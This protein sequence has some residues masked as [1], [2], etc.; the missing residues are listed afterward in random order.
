MT[1]REAFESRMM[2]LDGGMGSVIQTYGIKGANNDMLSIERPDVILD[3]QR[4]YVDAG[5]D[6][7]TTNTFSSQRVSQH[8]YHQEHRIAEMNR[9]SV[10]IARQAA[11]EAMAKY[12]RQV[13]IAGDVGPTS[14]MLS[15][16]DDVNDPASRS[17]TF[18][19]LEDAY[20]EQIQVLLEEGV[21]A[22]LIE[23]IFDTLNAKAALSAYSKAK[24]AMEAAAIA[25][26][27]TPRPVEV[28]LSMTVS[29]ASGRTL[30]GQT[31]EAFAISVMH[32]KPLSIGL[33]CGLGADGMIPYLRRMGK[34]A[35]CYLSCHPNAGLPNQFGGYDDTPEDMVRLMTPYMD[36]HLVNMIGGCCGTTPEHIAAM[37]K[38]LD[39]LP[40]DYERRKPAPKFATSPLLRLAGLEPLLVNQVRPSNGADNCNS[41][42]FVPVGERCNV[43]GS[44]KFLR[45]INEKNYEEALDIARK[46]V[47][48]GAQVVDVNMD[49]GLLDAKQEMRTFLNL[50]ASDPA[51][52]RVPIMVD[53]SR[54][55][56]IEEGLKCAQGKCIVNSISLKM[57]EEAFIEHAMT[58][59][60]LGAAVIVML[61]DEEGQATNY[62]RRVAI[63]SRAYK[64]ITEKCGFDPSDIIFDPNVLTVATGMAEH[65]AYAHDFIR[66]C[67][68]IIDNLPGVRISGGL[69]NL[70]FAF[71][72]N[73][74]LREAMHSTFLHLATPNGMG[75]AIMNPAAAVDYKTI[76]LELRMAITEVLLNTYPESS[77]ELIEIASRMTAAQ[78]AAKES[79]AK[80]DPKAIFAVSAGAANAASSES[81]GA[82]VA[83]VQTTPEQRLQEALLKGTSTTLQPD[84]ME[85]INRG[86]SPVNIISGPLMDGM[87]EVGRLFGEGKMF[88]PQVVKTARTMKKAV[89]ILQPYIEAGKEEG[90]ASR[91]KIVIATVKGDVHD[92]G[93]NIVSVIMA[94]NG[95][96]MVDLGVMVPEDVIVNA[97]IEHKADIVS[98]SGLITPSLEEMCTVATK[99]QEAGLRIPIIVG[100]ATTSPTHTAVKIAPCYDGPVFHVRDAASNPGLA[101][102][103]LDPSTSAETIEENRKEQQ[104][105]RDKQAGIISAAEEAMAAA[106]STPVERRYKCDWEKYQPV[107]PPFMGESKLPPI[108]LE[109]VIP[110]ISWEYFF[111]TWKVKPDC[112]EAIKLK[113]DAEKLLAEI[114]KPEYALRAVQAFYPAAGTDSTVQFNTGRTGT[115]ADLVEVTT[116]RQQ[117]PEGTCLALCDYVAP[118]DAKTASV[119]S[120]VLGDK[121]FRD[122][123]G[124]FAVTVSDT[125]VKRLEKLKAEQG[126]SD[127]DVLL[128]QTVAD[129]LAEAGA[130]YLSN[131]LDANNN[132]KG[133]RPAVGYPVLPNI[134]EIFN[135]AKLIDFDSVGISLTEN[136]AMYPQASVSGLYISHP[137]IEYF[138]VK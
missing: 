63:A 57:G 74:Y 41:E 129:R 101:Q 113:A 32:A 118:A 61:F 68:W 125:F 135:V 4:R 108:A 126:G 47:E 109:K 137:E 8:E 62:D 34:V 89:E 26:G 76:P 37:R 1:L 33:N 25:K 132:W 30:S 87:N 97:A 102:K 16:S 48:D 5:V 39:A 64:L 69:S 23:T 114:S 130:Q 80:Y 22:I 17:I 40:A 29:D 117:N 43:A 51:I 88:L 45:L 120:S 83:A 128:M 85:L 71:R 84:L 18:D 100:G 103:L 42:D 107:Q 90:A 92:I 55:E 106:E 93:K 78:M 79:G 111:Y 112:E 104:R 24:E 123:V 14:K 31:V 96:D 7:L 98:L 124:A 99:M 49:D 59:K 50:L 54:F 56:V 13:Y 81:A 9:A 91:G 38:M 53:S 127:Y 21:D 82:D 60:R 3:I 136:G 12:G 10:K 138:N 52:S 2:L 77:E 116:A 110:L 67:R 94:C 105:I 65:N 86:D 131:Q 119:F 46:Q 27:E 134:K 95:F 133:I 36:E 75:M 70:S 122:I 15:M 44:K 19:E 73:N 58:V 28:M 20:L 35:P 11:D 66:A 72:G 6:V 115:A 121:I